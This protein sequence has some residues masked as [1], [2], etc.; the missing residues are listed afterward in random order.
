MENESL[1]T[2]ERG[3]EVWSKSEI[4]DSS[5]NIEVNENK[6]DITQVIWDINTYIL[7]F[8]KNEE[9]FY[10]EAFLWKQIHQFLLDNVEV[11]EIYKDFIYWYYKERHNIQNMNRDFSPSFWVFEFLLS[12]DSITPNYYTYYKGEPNKFMQII[13]TESYSPDAMYS[14]VAVSEKIVN[15]VIKVYYIDDINVPWQGTT[16]GNYNRNWFCLVNL[17]HVMRREREVYTKCWELNKI[18]WMDPWSDPLEIGIKWVIADELTHHEQN[19]DALSKMDCSKIICNGN[20]YFQNYSEIKQFLSEVA[21]FL[22]DKRHLADILYIALSRFK[23]QY[24]DGQLVLKVTA[25]KDYDP[26]YQIIID[27][28]LKYTEYDLVWEI[29]DGENLKRYRNGID[30]V[31]LSLHY[32]HNRCIMYVDKVLWQ[33]TPEILCTLEEQLLW[34][35]ED[36]NNNIGDNKK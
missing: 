33:I 5:L 9:E 28:I 21:H 27:L 22:E 17:A 4:E 2:I 36:I 11:W 18:W 25:L 26:T 15:N 13:K 20:Q 19:Y 35:A 29:I 14:V 1:R 34:I 3:I 31:D 6:K 24:D 12:C 30:K 32:D 23:L 7:Q 16:I 10:D 8:K